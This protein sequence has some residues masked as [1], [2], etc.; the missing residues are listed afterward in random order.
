MM[1]LSRAFLSFFVLFLSVIS[2][3]T[4]HSLS[5]AEGAP[6]SVAPGT[7]TDDFVFG[8][9]QTNLVTGP[10]IMTGVVTT[11]GGA[12]IKFDDVVTGAS[13]EIANP[14]FKTT[15]SNFAV[16]TS[17]HD[18]TAGEVISGSTGS[19]GVAQYT[20][21]LTLGASDARFVQI[22]H[23]DVGIQFQGSGAFALR[24]SEFFAVGTPLK[25]VPDTSASSVT[26]NNLLVAFSNNGPT[27]VDD[28]KLT[29]FGIR[30]EGAYQMVHFWMTSNTRYF[31]KD[32]L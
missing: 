9:G 31:R 4:T 3:P 11:E 6:V 25:V 8:A 13:L 30:H 29:Y 32:I 16:F 1:K 5:L 28:G 15:S 19:P 2:F 10:T 21:A 18:T 22:R 27:I 7:I 17:K 14:D 23:A 12:I 24:D 26:L 20:N